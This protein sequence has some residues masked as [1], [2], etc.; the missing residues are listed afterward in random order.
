MELPTERPTSAPT[1]AAARGVVFG[2]GVRELGI[3]VVALAV[4]VLGGI[5]GYRELRRNSVVARAVQA[6]LALREDA[7]SYY[8]ERY[9]AMAAKAAQYRAAAEAQAAEPG[10]A[11]LRERARRYEAFAAQFNQDRALQGFSAKRKEIEQLLTQGEV[12]LARQRTAELPLLAFPGPSE[13]ERAKHEQYDAPLAEFSRR[14]P[15]LYRLLRQNE[16]EIA[17]QDEAALRAEIMSAGVAGVTPQLIL[18]VDLLAAVT[19]ADDPVVAEWSA[20]ASAIDYFENPDAATISAWRRT[21]AA[22]RAQDWATA[23]AEMQAIVN[24]KIRTRQPFRAAFGRALLK[25]N[26]D[27]IAAAYPYLAEAAAAG[28]RQART[29][30]AQAD[31][32]QKRYGSAQRWLEAAVADADPDAEPLLLETYERV[33]AT[34]ADETGRRI[35]LIER[36]TDRADASPSAWLMLG[37]LYEQA[38]VPGSKAKAL[39]AYRRAAAKGSVAADAEVARCALRGVG[40]PVDLDLARDAACRVFAAGP[41]EEIAGVLSEVLQRAP[42]RSAGAIQRLFEQEASNG[43]GGYAE[44]RIVDGPGVSQLKGQLARYLDQMGRYGQAARLYA[45]AREPSAVQRH[46][47]LTAA[48]AC[49]TCGGKGKVQVSAPCPTCGGKGKQIC[50][51]CGG[52]GTIF[53]PGT[54]PCTACGGSGTMVQDRKVVACSTCGGSGKGKGS[55]IKQDCTHCD[56][57]YIHCAE[58]IAGSI[59]VTKECPDCHGKGTWSLVERSGE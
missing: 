2:F 49:E 58:C 43:G 13:I 6:Q 14:D 20:L 52:T 26:P 46:A 21:Q 47:Q 1:S 33:P 38:D 23:T 4:L 44:K 55:V 59:K 8:R 5:W 39:A 11:W 18:K 9:A 50:S 29:W 7:A 42:D 45:N 53:V 19:P 35:G 51:F 48:H 40:G 17:R 31:L 57:G 16:P 25:R 56:H 30:V 28:D 24:A 32:K 37:R 54:P 22:Q 10:R 34:G 15:G 36:V 12:E 27:D 3:G 41:R